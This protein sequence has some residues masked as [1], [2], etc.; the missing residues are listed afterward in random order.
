MSGRATPLARYWACFLAPL[1]LFAGC[2]GNAGP[3]AGMVRFDDHAPVESGSIEFRSLESGQRYA[4]RIG[5]GGQFEPQDQDGRLG[6]PPGEYEVVVVQIVL[7][8]DLAA[9]AHE[10]GRTVPRRYADYYT[11]DLRTTVRP[12]QSEEIEVVLAAP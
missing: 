10:H 6:L 9:D 12:G 4:S 2:S 11:S 3:A 8:E 1:V 5:S 7:T